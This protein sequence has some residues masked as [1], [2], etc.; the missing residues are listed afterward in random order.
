VAKA[1]PSR[2]LDLAGPLARY[3]LELFWSDDDQ[4]FVV[5]APQFGSGV[6]ALAE[7]P[8][9]ALRE[10][11][12]VLELI[13]DYYQEEGRELPTVPAYSGQLRVRMPKSLHAALA[14]RARLEEVSLNTLIVSYLSSCAGRTVRGS[15]ADS[16]E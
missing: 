7:T 1:R 6:S 4:E 10:M 13:E 14:A 8:D 5:T 3:R 2:G 11:Q 9:A 16:G 15:V 12:V